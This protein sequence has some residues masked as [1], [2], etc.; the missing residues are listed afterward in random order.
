MDRPIPPDEAFAE[1]A[2]QCEQTGGVITGDRC[3]ACA[4]DGSC[5]PPAYLRLLFASQ[6]KERTGIHVTDLTGCLRRAFYTKTEAAP[7]I[8]PGSMLNVVLG[9]LVHRALEGHGGETERQVSM[10]Q[11][12]IRVVGSVD[13]VEGGIVE[14]KTT[15]WLKPSRLPYGNH[16]TQVTY[17]AV[18]LRE[19]GEPV[20]HA[21]LFYLDMSGPSRCPRCRLEVVDCTCGYTHKETHRGVAP[22]VIEFTDEGLDQAKAQLLARGKTLKQALQS[23]SPPDAEKSFLCRYCSH[24]ETCR[25]CEADRLVA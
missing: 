16:E 9:S 17:Y 10:E 3:I 15:R 11:D 6:L 1:V 19:M 5:F 12:G 20:D 21:T 2:V 25:E 22:Y 4:R 7:P 23:G 14:Y 24:R 13:A 8:R 18:L